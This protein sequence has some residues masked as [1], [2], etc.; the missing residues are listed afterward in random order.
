MSYSN[1][2]SKFTILVFFAFTK[3]KKRNKKETKAEKT[4][5]QAEQTRNLL[6]SILVIVCDSYLFYALSKSIKSHHM[7]CMIGMNM[8][9]TSNFEY[10]QRF[11]VKICMKAYNYQ[12]L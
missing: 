4:E 5:H 3:K 8:V 12:K 10:E 6:V 1:H 2:L 11:E 9:S 7:C